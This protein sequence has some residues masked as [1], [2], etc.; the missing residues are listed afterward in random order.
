M[1]DENRVHLRISGR[2]QGVGYRYTAYDVARQLGLRGWVRNT[3]DGC[4]ESEAEGP[5][6]AVQKYVAWCHKGPRMAHVTKVEVAPP[7]SGELP[8]FEI[9]L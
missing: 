4:V 6:R 1:T 5:S 7:A 3:Y 9:R 2:V 8:A